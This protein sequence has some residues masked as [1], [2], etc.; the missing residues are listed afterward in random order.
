MNLSGEEIIPFKFGWQVDFEKSDSI[1]NIETIHW[2]DDLR[3]DTYLLSLDGTMTFLE[4]EY[5]DNF[6]YDEWDARHAYDESRNYYHDD[7]L[8]A[9]EG[10]ASNR[11]N[12]D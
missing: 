2:G 7:D 12:I 9:F 5:V 6:D 10:D 3:R 1:E 4:S 11:W 8:D